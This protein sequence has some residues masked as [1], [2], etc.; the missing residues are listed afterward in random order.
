[1]EL[2]KVEGFEGLSDFCHTFKL[3][4]GRM[5]DANEDPTVVG[6]F[7]VSWFLFIP[8]PLCRKDYP[9]GD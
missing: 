7:K 8:P 4:R 1:M 6:E 3:Y 9:A 5:Q 2:E